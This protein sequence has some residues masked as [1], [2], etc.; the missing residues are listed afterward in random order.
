MAL[1][2]HTQYVVTVGLVPLTMLL[3]A[4]VSL[5]SPVANAL[6]IPVI[7]LLVTPLSLLGSVLPAPLSEW[8]LLLAHF[9]VQLLAQ[10]LDWLGARRFAVWTAPVPPAWSFCWA[11]VRH[12]VAAGAARLAAALGRHA[13]LDSAADGLAI[14]SAAGPAM[15]HG[16]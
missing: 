14:E 4:Q 8:V 3:F 11:A 16:V 6:A 12:P 10:V 5:V 2:A 13:E 7:S 9:L 1:G 15:G